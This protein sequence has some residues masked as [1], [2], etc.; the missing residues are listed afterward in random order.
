MKQT[1][2]QGL[3]EPGTR[4]RPERSWSRR[5]TSFRRKAEEGY[6]HRSE[7]PPASAVG[8]VK[9]MDPEGMICDE[10]VEGALKIMFNAMKQE[11]HEMFSNMFRFF[12]SHKDELGYVANFSTKPL[13]GTAA[14]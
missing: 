3:R 7:N 10:G 5:K 12:N 1:V 6:L 9:L 13:A 2:P 8:S 14:A 11:N 4:K